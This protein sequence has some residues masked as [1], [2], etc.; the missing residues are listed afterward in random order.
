MHLSES[1]IN[2][3]GILL[4][5]LLTVTQT[6]L[7]QG[8]PPKPAPAPPIYRGLR[9]HL[10]HTPHIIWIEC[11]SFQMRKDTRVFSG[12]RKPSL[13]TD[14]KITPAQPFIHVLNI[15]LGCGKTVEKRSSRC[16]SF[17]TPKK[18]NEEERP[19]SGIRVERSVTY[20]WRL[21]RRLVVSRL[22]SCMVY[23]APRNW[24]HPESCYKTFLLLLMI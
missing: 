15:P 12:N 1:H 5:Q 2:V 20:S 13:T 16:C 4:R 3:L 11:R 21:T 17:T 18:S 10:K 22:S 6:F 14:L 19:C 7:H 9:T 23:G 8:P 24:F